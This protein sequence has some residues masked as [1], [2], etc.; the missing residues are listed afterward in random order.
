MERSRLL[1]FMITGG[2]AAAVNLVSRYLLNYF[3]SFS[4]AVAIAYLFGMATAYTL[5]RLFVFERSG[6]SVADE[7]WRFTVVNIFAAAQVWIISVGLGEYL[8]RSLAFQWHPLEIAHLFGVSAPVLTSY[9]G[10]RHFSFA[11]IPQ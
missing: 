11:R 4:A 1:R 8:F 3:V 10:H 6:R 5:G 9:L 7:F 2:M